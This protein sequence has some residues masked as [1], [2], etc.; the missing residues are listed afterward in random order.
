M[1]ALL[2][3]SVVLSGC[4]ETP[5]IVRPFP[6][7]P[8]YTERRADPGRVLDERVKLGPTRAGEGRA[9]GPTLCGFVDFSARVVWISREIACPLEET[10]RQEACHIQAHESGTPDKCHDGRKF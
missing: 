10:R 4:A 8:S 9:G 7:D 3:A 5:P 1:R 6:L 2:L